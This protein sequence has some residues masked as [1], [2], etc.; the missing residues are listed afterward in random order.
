LGTLCSS[1]DSDRRAFHA[2][3]GLQAQPRADPDGGKPTHRIQAQLDFEVN[4][5]L[6]D[7]AYSTNTTLIPSRACFA[8]R[9]A[10]AEHVVKMFG[11]EADEAPLFSWLPKQHVLVV[12]ATAGL[13]PVTQSE[14]SC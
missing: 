9:C 11:S 5:E 1:V 2:N 10:D 6:H 14:F 13:L 12:M 8:R 3:A 7:E 4:T